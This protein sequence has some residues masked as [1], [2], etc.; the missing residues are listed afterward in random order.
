MCT[1]HEE[2]LVMEAINIRE[3]IMW[4]ENDEFVTVTDFV[5]LQNCHCFD[6]TTH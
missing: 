3:D 4:L 1:L 2:R 6:D 5:W